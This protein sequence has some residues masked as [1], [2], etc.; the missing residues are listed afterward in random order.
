MIADSP[1]EAARYTKESWNAWVARPGSYVTP[2][3]MP[4]PR[5]YKN[6]GESA[7][8][9][10]N[11][12]RRQHLSDLVVV[13]TPALTK[14]QDAA[15]F[16]LIANEEE[17]LG[18]KVGIAISGPATMGKSTLTRD[19]A[20]KLTLEQRGG[21]PWF[22]TG[23][24]LAE[25]H[26]VVIV[27]VPGKVTPKAISQRI[28]HFLAIP[29]R[30][31]TTENE[32]N[33][34]ISQHFAHCRVKLV[35]IDE[36]QKIKGATTAGQEASEHLK[37]LADMS[38]ATFMYVGVD[39]ENSGLFGSRAEHTSGRFSIHRLEPFANDMVWR[40]VLAAF[41]NAIR[42]VEHRSGVLQNEFADVIWERTGGRM[43]PLAQL[44]KLA[45]IR[46][47]HNGTEAI[48]TDNLNETVLGER[49]EREYRNLIQARTA[50]ERKAAARRRRPPAQH[51]VPPAS[52]RTL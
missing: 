10:F 32:L 3:E 41:D 24:I 44:I 1:S 18:S 37:D 42:L 5:Q 35:I 47:I 43:G 21:V 2:E 25:H 46:A 16:T 29:Y 52:P 45:S 31:S 51:P 6:M 28:C 38:G 7:K 36:C 39:L 49:E 13:Q 19:F 22:Q 40:T 34:R 15:L 9:S 48:T 17:A 33:V 8:S 26:P 23:P 11:R 12:R 27:T 14:I 20:R 50:W 4:T 30:A